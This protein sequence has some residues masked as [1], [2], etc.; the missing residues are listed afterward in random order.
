MK[1]SVGELLEQLQLLDEH[2]R[3]EAKR[4][5]ACGESMMETVCAFANEPGMNGGF[6]LLGVEANDPAVNGQR[7]RICGVS[8][9]D[10]VIN[11]LSSKCREQFNQPVRIHAKSEAVDGKVV[12]AVRVEEALPADKPIY[13]TKKPLPKSAWRRGPN[14]DYKCNER[15]LAELYR[16]KDQAA[17]D[18][19]EVAGATLDDIDPD[20]LND[21]RKARAAVNPAAE[22][23]QYGD[24]DLLKALNCAVVKNGVLIPTVAGIVLFGSRPSLRRLFPMLR[25]DYIRVEGKEWVEDPENRFSTIDMRDS[26]VRLATR[27]VAAILDDLP[28]SF[29]LPNGAL[30][31]QGEYLIPSKVIREAVVNALMHRNYQKAEPI[32]IIR[33]ANRLELRNPGYSIKD[34]EEFGTPGSK[35]RNQAIAAVLHEIN[36][37][38]TKGSG[39]RTMRTL[40][41]QAGLA[42]PIF[43]SDRYRDTFAATYLFHHFL[44]EEDVNWLAGFKEY[45]LVA[46]EMHALIF[47]RETGR[48][49]NA[50][51][52]ELCRVD[53][54]QASYHLTRLRDAG[55]LEQ[56]AKGPLTYYVCS[57]ALL[58]PQAV[59]KSE[60]P[61]LFSEL[62][63]LSSE[64]PVLSMELSEQSSQFPVQSSQFPVQS[65]QLTDL[66]AKFPQIAHC[67]LEQIYELRERSHDREQVLQMILQLC[68]E[69][70]YSARELAE[71][72]KRKTKYLVQSYLRPLL[73]DGQLQY[74]FPAEPN[75]PQQAY[76]TVVNAA[77]RVEK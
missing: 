44:S 1:E 16:Q 68:R 46:D 39:I 30:Q 55:L 5:S 36:L 75:H 66:A 58:N 71:I 10:R 35:P 15:D 29:R 61:S 4:G 65:S 22:E 76:C 32:Q 38:E 51:Y 62:P 6:L 18:M 59:A 11:D 49:T 48:I 47:V 50:D 2:D 57:A 63:T 34:V 64:L 73:K 27:S 45:A 3:I 53:T 28:K 41:E 12:I 9:P 56:V 70:S 33:Y 60:M 19:A 74:K 42:V 7:Y 40:M 67:L 21:Y 43:E 26:L 25:L 20:A 17:Y 54:L 14:G 23:L 72:L 24:A 8:D 77:E 52:R 69:Q 31:N 13:F 37:A